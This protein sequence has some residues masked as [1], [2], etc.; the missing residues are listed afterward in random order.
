M[1][2]AM[3]FLGESDIPFAEAKTQLMRCEI[4]CKRVRAR[5]YIASMGSVENRKAE[6]ESHK[7]VIDA[8]DA[9]IAATL[10]FEGLKAR[11]SRAEILIEVWR[12]VEASRRR[13]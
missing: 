5:I 8:D 6:A 11:R 9:Y 1:E 3:V 10:T 2:K 12:S 4:L 7:D 13:V